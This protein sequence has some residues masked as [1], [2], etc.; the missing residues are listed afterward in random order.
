MLS[1][2]AGLTFG[3]T[4]MGPKIV[5]TTASLFVRREAL[6]APNHYAQALSQTI[7]GSVITYGA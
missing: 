4:V 1:L 2:W 5:A 7:Q 3:M 6:T